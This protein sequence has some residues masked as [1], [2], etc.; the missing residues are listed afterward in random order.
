M[1]PCNGKEMLF[2]L[3]SKLNI[4]KQRSFVMPTRRQPLQHFGLI[5]INHDAT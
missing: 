5:G 1:C 4:Y 3:D 2:P